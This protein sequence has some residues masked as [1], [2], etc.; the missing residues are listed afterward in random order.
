VSIAVAIRSLV[1]CRA[2]SAVVQAMLFASIGQAAVVVP[3]RPR[4]PPGVIEGT[5]FQPES[6]TVRAG[7]TNVWVNKDLFPHTATSR[8]SPFNS[9][10][11]AAGASWK[12]V[13][14]KKGEFA[15]TCVFHPTMKAALIVN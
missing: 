15:Y 5:R 13:A 14:K 6:L 4:T 7:D 11:I 12:Y 2:F 10:V 9:Q 8:N 1:L 3:P